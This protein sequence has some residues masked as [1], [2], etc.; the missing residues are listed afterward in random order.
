MKKFDNLY[1]A[2]KVLKVL[3]TYKNITR[4]EIVLK[5]NVNQSYITNS[6]LLL[7]EKGYRIDTIN[8]MDGGYSYKGFIKEFNKNK[9]KKLSEN[10][11]KS[12]IKLYKDGVQVND[13]MNIT[14]KSKPCIFYQ[15]NKNKINLDRNCAI[16]NILL[17][18]LYEKGYSLKEI[19][20]MAN[21][22]YSLLT[23]NLYRY[24]TANRYLKN[25]KN[26]IK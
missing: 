6:I 9:N 18:D 13:I 16:N 26:L 20:K 4:T 12:I 25:Q 19:S 7:R 14:G 1:V 3:K 17:N 8:G 23:K 21:I 5:T 22:E 10:E 15:L 24:V 11:V 2:Y